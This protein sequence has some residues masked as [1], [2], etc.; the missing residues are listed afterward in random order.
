MGGPQASFPPTL[1]IA[2]NATVHL[3]AGGQPERRDCPGHCPVRGRSRPVVG[4]YLPLRPNASKARRVP[5]PA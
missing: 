5:S 4:L 1:L 3:Q 2:S